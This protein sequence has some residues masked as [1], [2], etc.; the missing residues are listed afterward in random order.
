[1]CGVVRV[2]A[3][4]LLRAR[5]RLLTLALALGSAQGGGGGGGGAASPGALQLADAAA[6]SS[7]VAAL[8]PTGALF[9]RFFMNG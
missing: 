2:C 8:A 9:V 5:L 6:L 3:L 7:A 1:M 4:T